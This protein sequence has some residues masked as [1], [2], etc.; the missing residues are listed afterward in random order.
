M[1][2]GEAA[3]CRTCNITLDWI[4][5]GQ[6]YSLQADICAKIEAEIAHFDRQGGA[7]PACYFRG[8][9]GSATGGH[10]LFPEGPIT[11]EPNSIDR[12]RRLSLA[13]RVY[14]R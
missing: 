7:P 9:L 13:S 4:Y 11:V 10:K 12:L 2:A 1:K 6:M 14:Q 5:R 8:D 3:R